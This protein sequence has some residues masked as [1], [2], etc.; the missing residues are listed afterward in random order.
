MVGNGI[1]FVLQQIPPG[2]LGR[3]HAYQGSCASSSVYDSHVHSHTIQVPDDF[4]VED[5]HTEDKPI[6]CGL[7][8]SVHYYRLW[9]NCVCAARAA[10]IRRTHTVYHNCTAV[11]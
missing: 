10:V 6:A 11:V 9:I 7:T 3:A 1:F 2:S 5:D 8:V 4:V